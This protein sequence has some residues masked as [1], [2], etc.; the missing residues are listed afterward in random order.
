MNS[1]SS[2]PE[3][4]QRP[5]E[6]HSWRHAQGSGLGSFLFSKF[7]INKNY[8]FHT[9]FAKSTENSK[10]TVF[11]NQ[12]IRTYLDLI[13]KMCLCREDSCWIRKKMWDGYEAETFFMNSKLVYTDAHINMHMHTAVLRAA[14]H[15]VHGAPQD[16]VSTA[17]WSFL[18]QA[19][20]SFPLYSKSWERW[21]FDLAAK[22]PLRIPLPAGQS[23]PCSSLNATASSRL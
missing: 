23:D 5:S 21:A 20:W 15:Y 10:E 4:K 12:G 13:W 8:M 2:P 14:H 3:A 7:Q 1:T 18:S 17:K 16:Y 6:N 9:I 22:A 19:S 11:K